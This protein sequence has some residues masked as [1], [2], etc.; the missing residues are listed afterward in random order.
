MRS[1]ILLK[2]VK[3]DVLDRIAEGCTVGNSVSLHPVGSLPAGVWA[4]A[5]P[6]VHSVSTTAETWRNRIFL[7][8]H[9]LSLVNLAGSREDRQLMATAFSND[10]VGRTTE[11]V[12]EKVVAKVGWS[13]KFN[14]E[15]TPG[16]ATATT[17]CL[18]FAVVVR[19][20]WWNSGRRRIRHLLHTGVTLLPAWYVERFSKGILFFQQKIRSHSIM[21]VKKRVTRQTD[22]SYLHPLASTVLTVLHHR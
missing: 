6:D 9:Y 21:S 4:L 5:T 18:H 20:P 12:W 1:I 19:P 14:K 8:R 22:M 15:L 16:T 13:S 10:A 17:L 7:V 11:H 3:Y 2:H